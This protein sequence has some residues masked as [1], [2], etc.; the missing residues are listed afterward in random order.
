[1]LCGFFV[2][3]FGFGEFQIL[4]PQEPLKLRETLKSMVFEIFRKRIRCI[5]AFG[6]CIL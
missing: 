3:K 5:R 2:E 1:M 4:L 6:V